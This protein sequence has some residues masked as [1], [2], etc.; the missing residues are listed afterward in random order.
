MKFSQFL[1]ESTDSI[2][3]GKLHEFD[4][5]DTIEG[6]GSYKKNDLLV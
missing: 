4:G 2:S 5:K 3:L 1:N 6:T